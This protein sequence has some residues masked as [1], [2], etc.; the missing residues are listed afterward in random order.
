[1]FATQLEQLLQ[2]LDLERIEENLFRGVS[3]KTGR[4]RIFGG[5]VLGQALV[6]AGRTAPR[7]RDAHSL[8]GYFLRPGDP[9]V[10]IIYEVDR[11]R[12]GKSFVTRRVVAIQHGHAIFSMYFSISSDSLGSESGGGASGLGSWC[13]TPCASPRTETDLEKIAWP[14]WMATTRRVEKLLPSRMRST[15]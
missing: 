3:P 13:S 11:I 14:C 7:D 4:D 8:H 12:D 10:P 2:L 9:S 6:A 5:Q 15:S 1:M